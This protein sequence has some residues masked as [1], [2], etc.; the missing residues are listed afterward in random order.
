MQMNKKLGF[1]GKTKKIWLTFPS[2][3]RWAGFKII[4]VINYFT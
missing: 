4:W 1:A 3:K 2:L